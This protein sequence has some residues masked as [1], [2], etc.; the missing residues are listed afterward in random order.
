[1]FQYLPAHDISKATPHMESVSMG[2]LISL[3]WLQGNFATL[4]KR[5][6]SAEYETPRMYYVEFIYTNLC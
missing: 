3:E 6:M 4:L 2:G 1:M 5:H